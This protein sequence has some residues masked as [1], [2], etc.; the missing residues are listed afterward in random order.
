MMTVQ[1]QYSLPNCVLILECINPYGDSSP[2]PLLSVLNS[3][4][5]HFANESKIIKGDK[6]LLNALAQLAH[7]QAQSILSGVSAV[8]ASSEKPGFDK[9]QLTALETG[10]F[11]LSIP[12]NLLQPVDTEPHAT[13]LDIQLSTV[14]LFDLVEALD[15]MC[16]DSQ[17]LPDL[18]LNLKPLSR[19]Q[20][21]SQ[22]TGQKTV[23]LVM[24]MASLAIAAAVAYVIPI[25]NITKPTPPETEKIES[26]PT[27]S[28]PTESAPTESV[29]TES[30]PTSPASPKEDTPPDAATKDDPN[31]PDPSP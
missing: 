1:R 21:K 9:L 8:S 22:G 15:Q 12:E 24:G 17:T 25:P 3:F 28:V 18:S 11:S 7:Q 16:D 31:E 13:A 30:A 19:R 26:L 10:K 20:V 5:C 29:P 23:P 6:D 2:R 27:E 14:Q 4:E